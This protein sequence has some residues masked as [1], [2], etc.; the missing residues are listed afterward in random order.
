MTE[1]RLGAR[2]DLPV[3]EAPGFVK[4]A[5]WT[6]GQGIVAVSG[7][8]RGRVDVALHELVHQTAEH[9]LLRHGDG[10]PL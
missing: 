3:I 1:T 7:V 5:E 10:L 4:G 6:C 8:G 2:P 9:V